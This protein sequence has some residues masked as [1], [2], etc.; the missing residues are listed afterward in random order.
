MAKKY[1]I[2]KDNIPRICKAKGP[3]PLGGDTPHFPTME[4]AQAYADKQNEKEF[5]LI[6]KV[7]P[8]LKPEKD[9]NGPEDTAARRGRRF[10]T[11]L[12]DD[13]GEIDWISLS[14]KYTQ[15]GIRLSEEQYAK[16]KEDGDIALAPEVTYDTYDD[17]K[18]FFDKQDKKYLEPN[19]KAWSEKGYELLMACD[20]DKVDLSEGAEKY[21]DENGVRISK[22]QFDKNKVIAQEKIDNPPY[23]HDIGRVDWNSNQEYFRNNLE[24]GFQYRI[25]E[26]EHDRMMAEL[27]DQVELQ[28]AQEAAGLE[29]TNRVL[30]TEDEFFDKL[31][32][33]DREMMK[34]KARR[35]EREMKEKKRKREKYLREGEARQ[36]ARGKKIIADQLAKNKAKEKRE[37]REK[38]QAQK[39]LEDK[40]KKM[41]PIR[42]AI[43]NFVTG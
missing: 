34:N 35:L 20:V 37:M 13:I 27:N 43:Y 28:R 16:F 18:K 11:V 12:K 17:M 4:A 3:C 15:E 6:T 42:R 19:G 2:G 29:V 21:Y 36:I 14:P 31:K 7:K 1:H 10:T 23:P 33:N 32:E 24:G 5:G 30:F 40:L 25:S 22:F 8:K 38:A 26:I 41:G 39:E 9:W